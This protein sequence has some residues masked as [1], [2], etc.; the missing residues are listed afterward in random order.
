ML[1]T[2][3]SLQWRAAVAVLILSGA[4]ALSAFAPSHCPGRVSPLTRRLRLCPTALP[5]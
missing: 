1:P 2:A 5:A 3:S 4:D